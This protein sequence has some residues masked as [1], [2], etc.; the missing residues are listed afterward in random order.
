MTF[1]TIP[2]YLK[3]EPDATK[4]HGVASIDKS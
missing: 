4:V 2:N 1:V 3:N